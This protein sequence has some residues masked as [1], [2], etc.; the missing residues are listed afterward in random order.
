MATGGAARLI[1]RATRTGIARPAAAV[2][3]F[4]IA[5]AYV[6]AATVVYLQAALDASVGE[7]FPLRPAEDVHDLVLVELGREAATLAMLAAVGVLVGRRPVERLAWAAVAFGIWDVGYYGWLRVFADW[8]P[9]LET[10]DLLFLIPA[11][12][13]GPVWAPIVVS[14][15]LIVFGLGVASAERCGRPVVLRRSHVVAGVGGGAIVVGSFLLDA[16]AIMDGGLPGPFAWPVFA[17]GM[18]VAVVAAV[19]ALRRASVRR[20]DSGLDGEDLG[21]DA[22][23]PR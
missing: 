2:A 11:P 20:A 10:P 18:I 4:A 23:T 15:A 5:M 13:V 9:S 7:I 3:V 6:E 17:L 22:I 14:A 8:P 21:R 16:P 1:G 19:D 12:W